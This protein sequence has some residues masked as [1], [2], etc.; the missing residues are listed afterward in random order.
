MAIASFA[1][2]FESARAVD[3]RRAA[4]SFASACLYCSKAVKIAVSDFGV[5][6]CLLELRRDF[7]GEVNDAI[8]DSHYYC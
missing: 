2:C 6:S 5:V 3:Y 4:L 7:V 8:F 1:Y